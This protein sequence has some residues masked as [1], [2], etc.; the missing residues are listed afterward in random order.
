MSLDTDKRYRCLPVATSDEIDVG[1]GVRVLPCPVC[2]DLYLHRSE[3]MIYDEGVAI[4]F[5]CEQCHGGCEEWEVAYYELCMTE[6]NGNT[7][8]F[9]R[10]LAR[11]SEIINGKRV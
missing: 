7:F 5:W 8:C 11:D 4:R 10:V 2:G 1:N 3:V 9:W 6:D